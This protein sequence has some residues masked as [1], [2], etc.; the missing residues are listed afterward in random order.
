MV[1]IGESHQRGN[2]T[3]LVASHLAGLQTRARGDRFCAAAV[4]IHG[5][6]GEWAQGTSHSVEISFA[7]AAA[8][9]AARIGVQLAWSDDDQPQP[10]CRDYGVAAGVIECALLTAVDA[11]DGQ[12]VGFVEEG[13]GVVVLTLAVF[14][15]Q[16]LSGPVGVGRQ[17]G[18]ASAAV[19]VAEQPVEG[20]LP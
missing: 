12:L 11:A 5:W 7:N 16:L 4:D 6:L 2:H 1:E 18:A 17:V 3:V 15:N 19:R 9:S 14:H 8:Q 20:V 13:G 10:L